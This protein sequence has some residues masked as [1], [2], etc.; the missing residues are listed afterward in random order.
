MEMHEDLKRQ[1]I[2]E[3][4]HNAACRSSYKCRMDV[5]D[6]KG[7]KTFYSNTNV[8]PTV[9]TENIALACTNVGLL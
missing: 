1:P 6:S 3:T 7:E 5:F 9:F 2:M 8:L 4:A